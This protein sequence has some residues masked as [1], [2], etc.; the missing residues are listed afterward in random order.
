MS[1]PVYVLKNNIALRSVMGQATLRALVYVMSRS[2][3]W[4]SKELIT[5]MYVDRFLDCELNPSAFNFMEE[6]SLRKIFKTDVKKGVTYHRLSETFFHPKARPFEINEGYFTEESHLP[7]ATPI[8]IQSVF[9]MIKLFQ[10][11]LGHIIMTKL[12]LSPVHSAGV[13]DDLQVFL[14]MWHTKV[15]GMDAEITMMPLPLD[16]ESEEVLEQ[17]QM[18]REGFLTLWNGLQTLGGSA[19]GI[20][21]TLR[22]YS[23]M[24]VR[25][26]YENYMAQ[27]H[28]RLRLVTLRKIPCDGVFGLG[29]VETRSGGGPVASVTASPSRPGSPAAPVTQITYPPPFIAN[30]AAK[31]LR[32]QDARPM[33]QTMDYDRSRS[34]SGFPGA[35]EA[36]RTLNSNIGVENQRL[37]PASSFDKVANA[38]DAEMEYLPWQIDTDGD[39]RTFNEQPTKNENMHKKR[40]RVHKKRKRMHSDSSGNIDV[41]NDLRDNHEDMNVNQHNN[42]VR[43]TKVADVSKDMLSDN[44]NMDMSDSSE[45]GDDNT[46]KNSNST[47]VHNSIYN[48][49]DNNDDNN[50]NSSGNGNSAKD[51]TRRISQVINRNTG[52]MSVSRTKVQKRAFKEGV[53]ARKKMFEPIPSKELREAL[54]LNRFRAYSTPVLD[55]LPPSKPRLL[56]PESCRKYEDTGN[57]LKGS[58]GVYL[59]NNTRTRRPA[60]NQTLDP[61]GE[62][63]ISSEAKDLGLIA[64][65]L[66]NLPNIKDEYRFSTI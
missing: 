20:K 17:N 37:S 41:F 21:R 53:D 46:E 23:A 64:R 55:R 7:P 38:V 26:L 42:E 43:D 50:G 30:D 13:L 8:P 5:R 45:S 12:P 52:A 27:L 35:V 59:S 56:I 66:W 49:D 57:G 3:A 19:L 61:P 6:K 2:Y 32:Y 36:T 33:M 4:M 65:F 60:E 9:A 44:S 58:M 22:E 14:S 11:K 34:S 16:P 29:P 54:K 51:N 24:M 10:H 25:P 47:V 48:N 39:T 28:K 40:K 18:T 31:T 62:N 15:K 1:E 63:T